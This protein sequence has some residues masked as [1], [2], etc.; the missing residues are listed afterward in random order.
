MAEKVQADEIFEWAIVTLRSGTSIE[1]IRE[2]IEA[3]DRFVRLLESPQGIKG[4]Q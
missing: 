2:E 3:A 1:L 4:N